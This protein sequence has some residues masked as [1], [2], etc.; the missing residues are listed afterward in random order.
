M[1]AG[2]RA[3][4]ARRMIGAIFLIAGTTI[5][6]AMLALPMQTARLGFFP[7]ALLFITV[8]FA[9][10]LSA[11]YLLEVAL[12]M[13]RHSNFLSMASETLGPI[14]KGLAAL[15]Y[16]LLLYALI[17]AYLS[18]GASAVVSF[19]RDWTGLSIPFLGA[20]FAFC[21]LFGLFIY[22]GLTSADLLN[23]LLF[24]LLAL[25]FIVICFSLA[26]HIE[27]RRWMHANPSLIGTGFAIAI[28][29]FGFHIVIP[30]VRD[31][32][33][34]DVKA[35]RRALWIG[36]LLPL[37]LYLIWNAFVLGA[38]D[39]HALEQGWEM[40]QLPQIVIEQALGS[41]SIGLWM[42][43]FVF[44][45]IITSFLGV[46]ISLLDFLADGLKIRKNRIGR[47]ALCLLVFIP[48]LFFCWLDPLG[49]Y[50]VLAFGGL[51][52]T[53]LLGIFPPVMA[54]AQRK[55]KKGGYHVTGGSL[56]IALTL[57]F[58]IGAFVVCVGA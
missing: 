28:T 57:L 17:T 25:I 18:G 47:F 29:S 14:G 7:A 12:H 24:C 20:A 26:P 49:F 3:L 11:L 30:S 9:L 16:V 35:C 33:D 5:G 55:K 58:F 32:L 37:V 22:P 23:R 6:A 42:S 45:A 52:V 8:W 2:A 56:L 48:P 13:P 36:G 41:L 43:L 10:M 54:W 4:R 51:L 21:L 46:S 50:R 19:A 44:L 38:V 53:A 15:I 40:G 31:Y 39:A 27:G 34:F 1:S